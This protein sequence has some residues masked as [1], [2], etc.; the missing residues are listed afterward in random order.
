MRK[1]HATKRG[2]TFLSRRKREKNK[3]QP[4]NATQGQ[5]KEKDA[6]TRWDLGRLCFAG[7]CCQRVV[8]F[9]F[10]SSC[11][12]LCLP[13]YRSS[14]C[15]VSYCALLCFVAPNVATIRK[16]IRD[17]KTNNGKSSTTQ[18]PRFVTLPLDCTCTPFRIYTQRKRER[19][20]ERTTIGTEVN[21][22]TMDRSNRQ[23][24]VTITTTAT[25]ASTI[26]PATRPTLKT[27]CKSLRMLRSRSRRRIQQQQRQQQKRC[28]SSANDGTV[29][30]TTEPP[31]EQEEKDKEAVLPPVVTKPPVLARYQDKTVGAYS[32]QTMRP[33]RYIFLRRQTQVPSVSDGMDNAFGWND[34]DTDDDSSD[35]TI[36]EDGRE[37]VVASTPSRRGLLAQYRSLSM[38]NL[39]DTTATNNN[40][41][42]ITTPWEDGVDG[43]GPLSLLAISNSLHRKGNRKLG[44]MS[45]SDD[46]RSIESNSS[47]SSNHPKHFRTNHS[48]STNL[49]CG[50]GRLASLRLHRW[51]SQR[52][53][54][55]R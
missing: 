39:G 3:T 12:V 32:R 37:P 53:S 44:R 14:R 29:C 22:H 47:S 17:N 40:N 2:S 54:V 26:R 18:Q 27:R 15:G 21:R 8:P 34:N 7:L 42:I 10:V 23:S 24:T 11:S 49:V 9:R 46:E 25:T 36:S 13:G 28:G 52:F 38:R 48:N 6:D 30:S 45:L 51:S 35:I 1:A 33:P 4:I 41:N 20:R 50:P 19:E 16:P 31:S 43:S 55:E 5:R